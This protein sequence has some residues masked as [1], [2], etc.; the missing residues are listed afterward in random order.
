MRE[1][2]AKGKEGGRVNGEGKRERG[3]EGGKMMSE[4]LESRRERELP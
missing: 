3:R 4:A 2:A 1:E